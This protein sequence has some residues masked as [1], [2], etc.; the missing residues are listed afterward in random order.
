M[1]HVFADYLSKLD[2]EMPADLSGF[3][4]WWDL[5]LHDF[6]IT[7]RHMS[8]DR[9]GDTSKLDAEEHTELDVMFETLTRILGLPDRASQRSA[10][11]GL[12]HLYHP[13]VHDI[14]QTFIDANP[15]AFNSKWLEQC[16]DCVVL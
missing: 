9:C 4:M 13:G 16:R 7:P 15:G 14:V 6:W 11:H 2:T 1:Y 8:V 5:V 12:G 3:Y 10:L